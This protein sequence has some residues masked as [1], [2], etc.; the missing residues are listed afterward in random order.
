MKQIVIISFQWCFLT[1]LLA[2]LDNIT[3]ENGTCAHMQSNSLVKK[4]HMWKY[5]LDNEEN[6]LAWCITYA[7]PFEF[8]GFSACTL[9]INNNNCS[10]NW[11]LAIFNTPF[12]SSSNNSKSSS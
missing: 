2:L 6:N 12:Y 3:R 1:D 4:K 5:R 8:H 7:V 11:M 9:I 10:A